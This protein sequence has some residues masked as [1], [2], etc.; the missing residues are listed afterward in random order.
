M[1]Y[2]ESAYFDGNHCAHVAAFEERQR[3]ASLAKR[4]RAALAAFERR[5]G[6]R[7]LAA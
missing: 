7:R 6:S 4:N 5:N 3:L 1:S 2:A